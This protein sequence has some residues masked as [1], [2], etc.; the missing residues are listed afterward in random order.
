MRSIRV[1]T[2]LCFA[3]LMLGGCAPKPAAEPRTRWNADAVP[4]SGALV[5]LRTSASPTSRNR[6]V[7]ANAASGKE[8]PLWTAPAG[9][10]ARLLGTN[11]S[12]IAIGLV[13]RSATT[14][15]SVESTT[16]GTGG[17]QQFEHPAHVDQQVVVLRRDGSALT[18]RMPE[19]V[20]GVAVS[21]AFLGGKLVLAMRGPLFHYGSTQ[22]PVV[23]DER[24]RFSQMPDGVGQIGYRR[25]IE[26]AS[27]PGTDS[28]AGFFQ[29]GGPFGAPVLGMLALRDGSLDASRLPTPTP[30]ISYRGLEPG[31]A[32]YTVLSMS[33]GGA[34]ARFSLALIDVRS[35]VSSVTVPAAWPGLEVPAGDLPPMQ[36]TG[37]QSYLVAQQGIVEFG[38]RGEL[39]PSWLWRVGPRLK[40][41]RTRVTLVDHRRPTGVTALIMTGADSWRWLPRFD[42]R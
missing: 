12:E 30:D 21:G 40:R 3:A 2:A 25:L 28:A 1:L 34:Q 17:V 15:V 26:I 14:D 22:P 4:S 20:L 33:Q 23:M 42:G 39:Q 41:T 9:Y 5:V 19:S 27:V 37:A 24:G 35:G 16:L 32:P 36:A 10:Y 8:T 18:A 6:L 11:A 31:P 38:R 7:L 29:Q 13:S